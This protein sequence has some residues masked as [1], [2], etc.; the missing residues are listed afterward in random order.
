MTKKEYSP[1]DLPL[2]WNSKGLGCVE[3]LSMSF[4]CERRYIRCVPSMWLSL[5]VKKYSSEYIT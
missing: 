2:A 3:W 5:E 4:L 1:G